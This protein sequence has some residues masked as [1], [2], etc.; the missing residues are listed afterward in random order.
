MLNFETL[1][2]G[3]TRVT[4]SDHGGV[5]KN[6]WTTAEIYNKT[7]GLPSDIIDHKEAVTSHIHISKIYE[8]VELG[9]SSACL[10]VPPRSRM[11]RILEARKRS[12]C[13]R[14]LMVD[15]TQVS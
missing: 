7:S 2:R 12:R 3:C 14:R 9:M 1:D 10:L 15:L 6:K 13:S 11:S 8:L 5:L 4:R